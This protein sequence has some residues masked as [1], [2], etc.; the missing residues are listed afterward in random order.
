MQN[1]TPTQLYDLLITR[2]FEPK[3]KDAMGKDVIDPSEA[4][5]FTFDWKTQ[6]K[7]YGTVVILIGQDRNLKIFFG[8]NIG[9]TMES[10]DKSDW[11]EFL[12]QLKQFT[13]RNNLMNFD[14]E[15]IN[16]LKYNMQGIAAIKEGLF[17]G[18]YGNKKISYSDQPKQTRLVI[19]HNRTLGEGDARFRYVESLFVETGDDQRFKLPFTNLIGGRAMARHVSEG[20]TP[21]DAFGQ[22]IC[23]IVKEMNIL[24]KFVRASKHKHFDGD[25]GVLAETAIRHYQD[26]KSKAKRIIS[27][28]GYIME[29]QNF[30]PAEISEA[31]AMAEDI[32]NMFIEQSL[33][34]RIE[35]A[36]PL[37]AKLSVRKDN[38]MKEI[39]EFESWA[40]TVTE[41]TWSTPDSPESES[42]LQKLMAQELPVGADATNAT[43]QLYDILGDDQLFDQLT[44]LASKDANADARPLIQARLAELGINIEMPAEEVPA[45]AEPD[46]AATPPADVPDPA[47]PPVDPA[48]PPPTDVPNLD[49]DAVPTSEDLDVDGVMMTKQSNM[50]SESVE[51]VIRL[52]QLLR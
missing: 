30:D 40:N 36:I 16:R 11:Y 42:K 28:R 45:P 3:L 47:A 33:D 29:L 35:E 14:I 7:N 51:R 5:M 8:D 18:Y 10:D 21:Y 37:L 26:L 6:K 1:S 20:G 24:G 19:K 52:A 15:N 50:S 13:V 17:E 27:Q 25:A 44:D 43:E 12:N 34:S 48:A 46:A 39:A 31:D 4:D 49:P 32:R 2:D 23:E 38:N 41:G 9:R 22:H